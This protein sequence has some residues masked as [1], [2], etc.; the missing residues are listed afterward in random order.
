MTDRQISITVHDQFKR[1]DKVRLAHTEGREFVTDI[2]LDVTRDSTSVTFAGVS[3]RVEYTVIV[4]RVESSRAR[5]TLEQS[6]PAEPRIKW[7]IRWNHPDGPK[8]SFPFDNERWARDC[9]ATRGTGSSI[10]TTLVVSHNGGSWR[11]L[12]TREAWT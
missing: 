2:T 11:E 8:Y 6:A 1:G 3:D 5:V 7:A 10:S 4:D 12:E 9:F